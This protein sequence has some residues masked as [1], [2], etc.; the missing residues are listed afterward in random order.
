MYFPETIQS[1]L[2]D[3]CTIVD[4]QKED[5]CF[6]FL[7]KASTVWENPIENNI[8]RVAKVLCNVIFIDLQIFFTLTY[9][10][11]VFIFFLLSVIFILL[12]KLKVVLIA[13]QLHLFYIFL[14]SIIFSYIFIT[15]KKERIYNYI[16][17][18]VCYT[19]TITCIE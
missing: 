6:M 15:E 19:M 12:I 3:H 10:V 5:W 18:Q 4:C 14:C 17:I 11:T 16:V 8:Q 13:S 2:I 7:M 1:F 9:L